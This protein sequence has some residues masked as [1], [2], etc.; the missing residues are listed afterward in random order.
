MEDF[1]KV[2]SKEK[3][4]IR[5]KQATSFSP[6]SEFSPNWLQK[7]GS[8][9]EVTLNGLY[10]YDAIFE[11]LFGNEEL[12]SET[13]GWL[14]DI[15]MHYLTELEYRKGMT[16]QE[17]K[18][19][20]CMAEL[21]E[22]VYGEKNALIYRQFDNN[23]RYYIANAL[24]QQY[25]RNESL[26]LFCDVLVAVMHMGVVYKNKENPKEILIYLNDR[27]N[28]M[29]EQKIEFIKELFL[30]LGY[31]MRVFWENHFA[32]VGYSQTMKI[33]EIELL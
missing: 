6:Y 24:V 25:E 33:D 27:K 28:N 20:E 31:Q 14:F 2:V 3:E 4:N 26:Y 10:R 30:P 7:N 22:G 8:V 5:F 13:K 23:D 15:Y 17:I 19:R 21:E 18:V 16:G 11:P 1:W 9:K 12:D 32:L 29:D